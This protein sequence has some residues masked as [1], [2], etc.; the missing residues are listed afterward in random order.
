MLW[1]PTSLRTVHADKLGSGK[2]HRS[3]HGM[4]SP[5]ERAF[6]R[7]KAKTSVSYRRDA[8]WAP[9]KLC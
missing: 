8:R 3:A 5:F 1:R 9:G 7:L 6:S 4:T 2:R